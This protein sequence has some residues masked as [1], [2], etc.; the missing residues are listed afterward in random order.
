MQ[1]K[2]NV[3]SSTIICFI[4]I[5]TLMASCYDVWLS[6]YDSIT[7]TYNDRLDHI[8]NNASS[9]F[10]PPKATTNLNAWYNASLNQ[11]TDDYINC[12]G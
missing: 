10:S 9:Y 12:I 11:I 6:S 4:S 1:I 5:S 7:A 2:K 8:Q 3:I